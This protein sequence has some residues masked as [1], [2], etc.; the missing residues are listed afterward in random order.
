MSDHNPLWYS[1][2]DGLPPL[3]IKVLVQWCGREFEAALEERKKRA[4][5]LWL[6][7]TSWERNRQLG[8]WE[9]RRSPVPV[10][11]PD[12][13]LPGIDEDIGTDPEVWRP[14]KPEAWKRPLPAPVKVIEPRMWSSRT[15]FTAVEEAEAA[16]LAREM[17]ADRETARAAG[18]SNREGRRTRES[19]AWWRDATRVT[20]SAPGSIGV[21][22]AEARVSRALLTDGV[23]AA[24]RN[25]V[26][27]ARA[28]ST[29]ADVVADILSSDDDDVFERVQF[30]SLPRDHDDYLTAMAWFAA[31]ETPG[32]RVPGHYSDAERL[33]VWRAR[34][35]SWRSIA[36]DLGCSD[37][38][39]RRQWSGALFQIWC[40]ANGWEIARRVTAADQLAV[41]RERNRQAKA[42][43]R[44]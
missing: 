10:W 17:E 31:L 22:E 3:G 14:I 44:A 40:A 28:S 39:A 30:N 37:T 11:L 1:P 25:G 19:L 35:R 24:I 9:P 7:A 18:E 38:T 6:T 16:D 42:R 23:T 29:L 20:Y 13:G 36:E 27:E 34:G 8:R 33:L 43:E 26:Q 21:A 41:L 5:Y 4:G 15:K 2:L 32:Q 12:D